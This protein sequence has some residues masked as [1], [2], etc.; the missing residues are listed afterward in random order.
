MIICSMGKD[1][2]FNQTTNLCI[3]EQVKKKHSG[4]VGIIIQDDEAALREEM[5]AIF[6][7]PEFVVEFI[8]VKRELALV[9]DGFKIDFQAIAVFGEKKCFEN[10]R[11]KTF[12][13]CS[14]KEAIHFIITDILS[15][16]SA[17]LYTFS[18]AS[19]AVVLDPLGTMERKKISIEYMAKKNLLE[20]VF[21]KISKKMRPSH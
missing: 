4:C 13:N 3:V 21:E 2:T 15:E 16:N 7:E 11:I 20:P 18:E 19:Q 6:D 10:K 5:K 12:Y 1:S 17:V 14:F 9:S 8:H